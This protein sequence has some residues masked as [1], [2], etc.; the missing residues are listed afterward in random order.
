MAGVRD[1]LRRVEQEAEGLYQTL[2]LE[3]GTKILYESEEMLDAISA[4]IR[5]EENRLLPVLRRR[6]TRRGYQALSM[7]CSH[8]M[9]VAKVVMRMTLRR[10]I[11]RAVREA[12]EGA[13][14]IRLRDGSTR[15]FTELDCW[16]AM[17]LTRF[18]LFKG[19]A[20]QSEVLDAVRAAT[21]ESR[22]KFEKE[23]GEI[24]M[25][26]QIIC[27]ESRGGWVEVYRLTEAGEVE[28]VRHEGHTEGARRLREEARQQGPAFG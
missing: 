4:A 16:K 1:R 10:R 23:Y 11:A 2:T 9:P 3:D 28:K 26:A 24:E 19:E 6:G 25:E 27:H 8:P 20:H 21:P 12:E 18:D 15:V 13:E 5:G 17:F 22:A 14:L 7:L